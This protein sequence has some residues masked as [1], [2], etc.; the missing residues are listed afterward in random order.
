VVPPRIGVVNG[1]SGK[2][3]GALKND[4][5]LGVF[6]FNFRVIVKSKNA[7][8]RVSEG[9][10]GCPGDRWFSV[11]AGGPITHG[12]RY[13]ESKT[14]LGILPVFLDSQSVRSG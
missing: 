10:G 3:C 7:I 13:P 2:S 6:S 9:L 8:A 1:H 14:M 4:Y 12:V 5:P 11:R